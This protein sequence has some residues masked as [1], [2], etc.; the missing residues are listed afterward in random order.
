MQHPPA[1][2]RIVLNRP[3]PDVEEAIDALKEVKRRRGVEFDDLVALL[4]KFMP[5]GTEPNK[6]CVASIRA[7]PPVARLRALID[8]A[9]PLVAKEL[10]FGMNPEVHPS[11]NLGQVSSSRTFS[12]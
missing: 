12:T 5:G 4:G 10:V 2:I 1:E 8:L 3:L 6:A 11:L 9:I 7:Y